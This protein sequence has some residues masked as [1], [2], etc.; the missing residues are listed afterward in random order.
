MKSSSYRKYLWK[1]IES[2]ARA[3]IEATDI[4]FYGD[5]KQEELKKISE[6]ELKEIRSLM[7]KLEE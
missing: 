1:S 4:G 7:A 2:K 5:K 6:M 3:M